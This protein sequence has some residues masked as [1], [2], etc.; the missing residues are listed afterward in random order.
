[1]TGIKAV[2]LPSTSPANASY[3]LDRLIGE[4]NV[5]EIDHHQ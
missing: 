4:W 1:M 5:I 3:S 2:K